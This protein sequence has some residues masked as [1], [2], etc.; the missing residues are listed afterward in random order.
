MEQPSVGELVAELA[1]GQGTVSTALGRLRGQ[2]LVRAFPSP[3]DARRQHQRVTKRGRAV[4]SR[5]LMAI[6]RQLDDP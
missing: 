5:F 4:V 2:E 1:L 3:D 6:G